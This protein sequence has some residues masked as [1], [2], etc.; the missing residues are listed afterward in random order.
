MT[1]LSPRGTHRAV[2]TEE[3]AG[4]RVVVT[5]VQCASRWT[6]AK[7]LHDCV[8]DAPLHV[9][10]DHVTALVGILENRSEK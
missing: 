2:L 1:V 5:R 9:A 7:Q 4:V 6:V 10:L 3:E 8:L